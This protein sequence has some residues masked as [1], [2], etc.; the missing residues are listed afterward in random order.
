MNVLMVGV[1]NDRVDRRLVKGIS[2]AGLGVSVVVGPGSR[3]EADAEASGIPHTPHTFPNRMHGASIRL[4][5]RMLAARSFDIVH[6][7]TNRALANLL[8][9]IRGQPTGPGIVAYRGTSGHL[10]RWDPASRLTYL[11]PRVDRI[12]CVSNAVRHYLRGL[13]VPED[14]LVVIYKGH[15]PDWYDAPAVSLVDAGIPPEVLPVIFV[16]NMRPV[17]GVEVLLRA[18]KTP[19][20]QS[21]GIHLVLVGEVRDRMVARRLRDPA[22]Q[23]RVTALGYR[24]DATALMAEAGIVVMPSIAREGLGKA[25]LEGMAQGIPAVVS[26]VGG[27]PEVVEHGVSGWV[28]PPGDPGALAGALARLAADPALRQSL[29]EAARR[30]IEGPFHVRHTVEKTLDLYASLPARPRQVV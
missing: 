15:D 14:T 17:K 2:E 28:V 5:R 13:S 3:A 12:V 9:A 19:V 29:G 23:G 24:S 26:D 16:G 30:R 20:V 25:I 1:S 22:L 18:M 27:M 6:C 10:S 21:V 4:L 7:F 11:H 8:W